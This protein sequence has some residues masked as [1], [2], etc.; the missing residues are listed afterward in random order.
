[1]TT[2]EISSE[3]ARM[4]RAGGIAAGFASVVG[5]GLI[6]LPSAVLHETGRAAVLTWLVAVAVCL[7]M[8][9][10]F[11]DTVLRAAGS[12][13][14]LRDTVRRGLGAAWGDVIPL[15]FGLVVIIGLPANAVV[16][17]RN[18]VAALGLP[19][20]G[21]VVAA[22]SLGLAV[23]ANL[24]GRRAG[25][26]LQR[27]G[28]VALIAALVGV[29]VW[30]FSHAQLTVQPVPT[31]AS[32][33]TV[34]AGV[35]LAFWAF[36]GFENLTFL[37][38]DLSDAGRD[39]APVAL[40]TLALLGTLAVSL[41]IAVAVQIPAGSVDPV[42]GLVDATR[43]LPAGRVV[44]AVMAGAGA[45]GILLNAVAWVR[46]VGLVLS[47]AARER[48][49]PRVVAGPDEAQPRRAILLM[50]AGVTVTLVV[51]RMHPGLVVD[52]LAAASAVFVMIY[53][54]CIAAYARSSGLRPWSLANLALVPLM[55]WSLW[56]SGARA[57]YAVI[58]LA[59]AGTATYVR[60]S[61]VEP[62]ART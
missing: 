60:R 13:D 5:A 53:L 29:V 8:I 4:G 33:T 20:S 25:A 2:K 15:M 56:E 49:L 35:L 45:L 54:I 50:T 37:A 23:T 9:M 55:L 34:P 62:A 21:T 51:L 19:V 6:G 12:S 61:R 42:T 52:L 16:A 24:V 14:P 7:P 11:R 22:C 46:G 26:H 30:S 32:L 17:A 41:T 28:A 31:V 36:V 40:I 27:A 47:A 59:V 18:L 39:F 38:R 43:S 44:A 48:L 3:P 57:L 58:V 10:L 1:V